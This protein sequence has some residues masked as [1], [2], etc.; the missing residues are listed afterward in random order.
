M[1]ADGVYVYAIVRA[2]VTPPS[3]AFGVGSPPA[4]LWSI[5]RG[6]IAA[7]V[8]EAPPKLRARRRDLLAHQ[9]LLQRLAEDG[10]VLPMRF[11][12]VAPDE[13]SV[14]RQLAGAGR[15]HIADLERLSGGVEVNM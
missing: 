9:D 11:G 8:S 7:V 13:E 12:M 6:Q 4:P 5:R 14:R 2:A 15:D 1:G 10:P 3:D